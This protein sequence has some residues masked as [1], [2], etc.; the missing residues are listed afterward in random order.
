M[1]LYLIKSSASLAILYLL[2]RYIVRNETDHQTNRMTA[3]L[4]VIFSSTFALLPMDYLYTPEV[5]PVAL[6][7][8]LDLGIPLEL[9][10]S[11]DSRPWAAVNIFVII[12]GAGVF[13]L[14]LRTVIGFSKLFRLYYNAKKIKR[15]GFTVAI[16]KED[17]S[18]FTLFNILFMGNESALDNYSRPLIAHEQ[19]H[20]DQLHSV[21]SLVLEFLTILFWFNPFIWL[22]RRDIR[23]EHEYMADK[24]VLKKGFQAMNYQKLLFQARTGIPLRLVN[25]FNDSV[26]LKKR[27]K[28]MTKTKIQKNYRAFLVLPLMAFIIL[29]SAFSGNGTMDNY[30]K[31]PE[32]VQ[33]DR[34]MYNTIAKMIEYPLDD[35]VDKR[36]G[37][38]Y[39]SFTVNRRGEVADVVAKNKNGLILKEIIVS[40]YWSVPLPRVIQNNMPSKAEDNV[41][42]QM[43]E[44]AIKAVEALGKFIPA[45]KDG[46]NVDAV[47]T[48]PIQFKLN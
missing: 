10:D 2:Y 24:H 30:D 28:M 5:Y 39:I 6:N 42:N 15:W 37:L 8:V 47:L 36:V 3:L 46:E 21:D 26:S 7:E 25:Y 44:K 40:G 16:L 1:E 33:G 4:C 9:N 12:Y 31:P 13:L 34:E 18:P 43:K 19:F 17:I 35:R 11:S 14:L 48:I 23:A 38:V 29:L 41:S 20:R 27:F 22:F 45:Q 32:Y